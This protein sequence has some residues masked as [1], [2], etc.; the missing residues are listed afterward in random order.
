[1]VLTKSGLVVLLLTH[2]KMTNSL[3]LSDLCV[4]RG[5]GFGRKWTQGPRSRG[6][7]GVTECSLK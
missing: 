6:P 1:M 3:K 2:S 4:G 5:E 7:W